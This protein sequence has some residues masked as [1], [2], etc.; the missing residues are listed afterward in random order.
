MARDTMKTLITGGSSLLGR[1][2]LGTIPEGYQVE[3]TWYTKYVSP[4]VGHQLNITD[5]SQVRYIFDRIQPELVI[6]CAA[7]GSVDYAEKNYSEAAL[8]NVEGTENILRAARDYYAKVI[9]IS[10]NAVFN[11][12]HPPYDESNPCHPINRYGS[13]KRQAEEKVMGYRSQW[14]IIRPFLLYGWPWPGGRPNW[15]TLVIDKL[16]KG[17]TLKLVN[18]V[19]WQP[20]YVEDCAKAIWQL[21]TEGQ[22]IYHIAS[23]ERT[24]LYEFGL[25]V[26]K[27]W[28]L[29]ETPLEPVDSSHFATMAPRPRDTTYNLDKIKALGI[30]LDGIEAG[31]ERMKQ[32][33]LRDLAKEILKVI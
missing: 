22:G 25:K 28:G 19:V 13:I 11:G 6:H 8:V 24:T 9:Y 7:N 33:Q 26:A 31:L 30:K 16:T 27:V 12:N 1:A 20:T 32:A 23:E 17:E 4:A 29:D 2:L 3:A 14:Q 15:A 10:T 18:D 21:T 5:K